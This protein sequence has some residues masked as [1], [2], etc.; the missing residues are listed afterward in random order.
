MKEYHKIDGL[1]MREEERPHKLIEGKFRNEIVEAL[2]DL[3]WIFTEKIDGTNIRV[4]WDG[5]KVTFGGRTD[6]AQ[7]PSVLV[8]KLNDLFMGETNAQMFEQK[9][10]E[11]QVTLYGEGYGPKIQSGGNY[12]ET[13]FV[14]FDV[15]IGHTWLKHKDVSDIAELFDIKSVPVALVGTLQQGIDMAKGGFTS[16]FAAVER[17]AEGLVG[18]PECR[19]LD[20]MGRRVIVKLKTKDWK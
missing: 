20:R 2:K 19:V 12:G 9:F 7:I 17:P 3:Q 13:G 11:T 8:E 18:V 16:G 1:Y 6:N 15:R 4:H 5:H 14:L 10:G